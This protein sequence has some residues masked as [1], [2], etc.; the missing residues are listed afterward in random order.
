MQHFPENLRGISWPAG[1]RLREGRLSTGD[2]KI[3]LV[4][5]PSDRDRKGD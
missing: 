4:E 3:E 1:S 2:E 5:L